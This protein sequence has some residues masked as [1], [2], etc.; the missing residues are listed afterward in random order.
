MHSM[1]PKSALA[2]SSAALIAAASAQPILPGY[3]FIKGSVSYAGGME[4]DDSEL[5]M[6]LWQFNAR[7]ILSKPINPTENFVILPVIDYKAT[8]MDIE[9]ADEDLHSISLSTFMVY[10][11]KDS[12]WMFG[13]WLRAEYASD[14][15]HGTSDAVT[16]DVIA[17]A[18]YK[19]SDSLTIGLGAAVVNLN[20]DE[21]FYVGPAIDWKI[22]PCFRVSLF[23]PNAV[24]SWTPDENWVFSLAGE[25]SGDE[26]TIEDE[27]ATTGNNNA[28]LDLD[29]YRV[30]LF[31][32]RRLTGDLWLRVG[33]GITVANSLEVKSVDGDRFAKDDLDEGFFGEIALRLEIW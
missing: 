20:N 8:I 23:G 2:L 15:E 24:A 13:G 25:A 19:F 32:N 10:S 28:V 5:E 17:G 7:T 30:G 18:A 11:Q 12:P 27:F 29:S 22:S 26:W 6:E 14:F 1:L 3:D 9:G 16:F 33:G 21:E 4:F 31:A